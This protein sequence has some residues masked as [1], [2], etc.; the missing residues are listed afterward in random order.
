M[1][2]QNQVLADL[3]ST[4]WKLPP[5]VDLGRREPSNDTCDHS[6]LPQSRLSVVA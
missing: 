3:R 2:I 6:E 4:D 5:R 1:Y